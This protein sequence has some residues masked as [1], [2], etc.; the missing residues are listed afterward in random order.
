MRKLNRPVLLPEW[1]EAMSRF[2]AE[3]PPD[4]SIRT[5]TKRW[6]LFKDEQQEAYKAIR[7]ALEQNQQG[8][9]AFCETALSDT[10]RQIEH[11]IPKMLTSPLEEWTINFENY[12]LACKGN[13]NRYHADYSDDPSHNANLTCGA[14]KGNLDPRGTICNP[15][16][17]PDE[18]V[19]H[20]AYQEDGLKYEPDEEV[21]LKHNIDPK[22]VKST[23]DHLGLNSPNLMR[24]R[25]NVWDSLLKEEEEIYKRYDNQSHTELDDFKNAELSPAE[26][27][28]PIFITLRKLFFAEYR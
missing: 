24:R 10:N 12:T 14:R 1:R 20:A 22:L 18:P 16:E 8:L 17:L 4:M 2:L 9:C 3:Y 23:I 15:Y 26:G 28:L 25:K 5:E 21:C 13:E 19:F 11:F 7:T 6:E 27:R